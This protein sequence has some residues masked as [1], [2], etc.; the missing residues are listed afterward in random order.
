MTDEELDAIGQNLIS[1]YAL[2]R[3]EEGAN[4]YRLAH[5][6]FKFGVGMVLKRKWI[7]IAIGAIVAVVVIL[8]FTG[9]L[10]V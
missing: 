10:G 2:M 6:S 3:I 7:F 5:K 1:P 4:K 8:Y 9:N